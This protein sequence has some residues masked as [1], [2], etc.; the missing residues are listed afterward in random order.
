[1][2]LF[3]SLMAMPN[4]LKS[5]QPADRQDSS[6]GGHELKILSW[7]IYMLPLMDFKNSNLLRGEAIAEE[8]SRSDYTILV[9]QEAFDW[10]VRK[11]LREVLK[12]NFPFFYGPVNNTRWYSIHTNSGLFIVSRIPLRVV[13]T[14]QFDTACGFDWFSRKGAILLEGTWQ[15]M[16]F[17]LVATHIQSDDYSWLVREKQI[18]EI[19]RKLLMPYLREGVPQIICGDFNTDREQTNHYTK[20]LAIMEAED[21]K[22][23]G[24]INYSFADRDNEITKGKKEKPRIIDYILIRNKYFVKSVARKIIVIKHYWSGNKHTLS[25]H[26]AMEASISFTSPVLSLGRP[27]P[28]D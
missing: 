28:R 19:Q 26:Y 27:I 8:L 3:T 11:I 7:N 10:R 5:S 17:Q 25:D 16:D 20:M 21:G 15:G 12:K 23:T 1:M 4:D 22:L 2:F 13:K 9:F 6:G 18:S 24:T 14:I